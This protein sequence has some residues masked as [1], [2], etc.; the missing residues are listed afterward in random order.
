MGA[1]EVGAEEEA[2]RGNARSV[3]VN[4][5]LSAKIE[6]SLE[7]TFENIRNPTVTVIKPSIRG[8][9]LADDDVLLLLLRRGGIIV[10]VIDR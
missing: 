10:V 7:F 2:A 5:Y 9:C 6:R 3:Y 4:A 1:E 8:Q